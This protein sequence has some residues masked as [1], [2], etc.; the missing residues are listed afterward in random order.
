M[1]FVGKIN[2]EIYQ[3]ITENI[4]T[5]E[6]I[7]TDERI[8]HIRDRHPGDYE[9]FFHY[10]SG[11]IA[12]PDYIIASNKKNTAVLLKNFEEKDRKFKVILR[13]KLETEPFSYK[14]SI[15]SFWHIGE[16]TWKKTIKN[17]L[18]LYKRT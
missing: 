15:V 18:V 12:E 17:K 7:I 9:K 5:D 13:L 3:C 6:V 14:N 10:I 16:T 2:K 8:A 1:Q 4:L 11:I